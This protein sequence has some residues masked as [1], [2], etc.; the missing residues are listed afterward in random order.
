[1]TCSLAGRDRADPGGAGTWQSRSRRPRRGPRGRRRV[2]HPG[3]GDALGLVGES[4]CGKTG[5]D[6]D[7]AGDRAACSSG[8]RTSSAGRCSTTG[9]D[10]HAALAQEPAGRPRPQIGMVFQEPMTALNPVMR[11]GDQIAEGPRRR[12]DQGRARPGRP[13]SSCCSGSASRTRSAV[14]GLP[15]RALGRPAPA[16]DD[17]DRARLHAERDPVRRADDGPRRDDPGPDPEA[18]AGTAQRPRRQR[19]LRHA[20]PGGGRADVPARRGHVRGR[21]RGDRAVAE[22]FREPR[23]PYTTRTR[24]GCCARCRTSRRP[25]GTASR[26]PGAPPDLVHPPAGCRFHPRCPFVQPDCVEGEFPLRASGGRA[27]ACIHPEA[28]VASAR[29]H[30]VIADG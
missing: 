17:R 8:R 12:L 26:F 21:G 9:G 20:R 22:V 25:R 30:A 7:A 2:V 3:A 19:R 13:R 16:G 29:E 4:G 23:H 6:D 15:A 1:M 24:S 28:A 18:A 5:Q 11:V 10:S 14:R 27:T